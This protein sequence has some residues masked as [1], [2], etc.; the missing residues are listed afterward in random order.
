MTGKRMTD[1]AS[2]SHSCPKVPDSVVE[3]D[4]L[5]QYGV[6]QRIDGDGYTYTAFFSN[7]NDRIRVTD[8]QVFD[9]EGII[10]SLKHHARQHQ[11]GKIFLKAHAKDAADFKCAG[12]DEEARIAGYFNGDDA[13]VL[14]LFTDDRRAIPRPPVPEREKIVASARHGFQTPARPRPLPGDFRCRLATP[15]DAPALARVFANNFESYPFPVFDATYVQH[16][17]ANDVLYML[18]SRHSE[19]AAVAS[20][21]MVPALSNA[22]MTD[23]ATMP[24][25]RGNGLGAFLLRALEIEMK[26]RRIQSLYTL[27]RA[28]S[29]S[30]NRIFGKAGYRYTG[31]LVQN[32]HISGH[33][34]D[35]NCW[36]KSLQ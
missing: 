12:L 19:I 28:S 22:E 8:Y 27:S 32:C 2:I 11:H 20:A 4:T 35:M 17:M 1:A 5:P 34:E 36:C 18:I 6:T 26:K 30:I 13:V 29:I 9:H 15:E 14:S 7:R 31:T 3:L 21:E 16:T 25:Y 24:R 33:F 10:Q 23:F